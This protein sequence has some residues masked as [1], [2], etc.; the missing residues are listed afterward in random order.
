MKTTIIIG[1]LIIMRIHAIAQPTA[2]NYTFDKKDK[3]K[4]EKAEIKLDSVNRANQDRTGVYKFNEYYD[5]GRRII[6]GIDAPS[7]VTV[8]VTDNYITFSRQIIRI[9]PILQFEII[10]RDKASE[11]GVAYNGVD[12]LWIMIASNGT[13]WDYSNTSGI[14]TIQVKIED[15]LKISGDMDTN[16]K[17]KAAENKHF[18]KRL[19]LEYENY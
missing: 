5:N 15:V 12:K 18:V 2:N 16:E 6:S 4:K 10:K 13:G 9:T 7:G 3:D 8:T 17:I 19:S 14:T 11:N 1:L